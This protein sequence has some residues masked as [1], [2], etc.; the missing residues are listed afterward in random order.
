MQREDTGSGEATS[1][2]GSGA[3]A[4]LHAGPQTWPSHR[5]THRGLQPYYFSL[6]LRGGKYSSYFACLL[7]PT[8]HGLCYSL[9][10]RGLTNTLKQRAISN[11][12]AAPVATSE[13]PDLAGARMSR[14]AIDRAAVAGGWGREF[15]W[16]VQTAVRTSGIIIVWARETG[17]AAPL[18]RDMREGLQAVG[19][20][21][22]TRARPAGSGKPAQTEGT[23]AAPKRGRAGRA[24]AGACASARERGR[25]R[26]ACGPHNAGRMRATQCRAHANVQTDR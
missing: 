23:Q 12:L 11:G 8:A 25:W 9:P 1:A 6:P 10:L 21:G 15:G 19:Q 18:R 16:A 7:K 3:P 13:A 20:A 14:A 5:R 22:K 26:L 4:G 2:P 24:G 17:R